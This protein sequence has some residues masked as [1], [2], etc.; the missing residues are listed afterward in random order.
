MNIGHVTYVYKPIKGGQEV[1]ID[2]L[3]KILNSAGYSQRVYQPNT[4]VRSPEL[5]LIPRAP[6]ALRIKALDLYAYNFLLPLVKWNDLRNE[7]ALIAHYAFHYPAVAWHR[8]VIV[9]SHGVE[10]DEPAVRLN[11]KIRKKIAQ[12]MFK[13]NQ[14]KLVANDTDYFRKMG[15]NVAPMEHLFEEVAPN[16]W[17]IP[18]CIDTFRFKHTDGL[19]DLKSLNPILV[20]RN[21]VPRRGIHLAIEAFN[22]FVK[23]YSETNLVIVGAEMDRSYKMYLEELIAKLNLTDKVYFW[24]S[25]AWEEMPKIYSSGLMT[26]IPSIFGEGT[27]LSALESMACG[28]VTISTNVG[29]LSDLPCIHAKPSAESLAS[30]MQTTFEKRDELVKQQKDIVR[31]T[32]NLQNW[33]KAWL[34]VIG[35]GNIRKEL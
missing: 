34:R 10:W 23:E 8:N 29:G 15:L 27:S 13:K 33:G 1:Y 24:G 16:K 18:N 11:H 25:V 9:V 21:I 2:N 19:T 31:K 3:L 5:R 26:L 28:T 32:Y 14:C 12:A 20:P 17:F 35:N 4:G 6:K 7:D 22:I 30:T